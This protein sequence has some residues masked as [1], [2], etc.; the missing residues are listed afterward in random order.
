M[1]EARGDIASATR[2]DTNAGGAVARERGF[3]LWLTVAPYA[4]AFF[5]IA[6]LRQV[7][8]GGDLWVRLAS[9]R[10]VLESHAVPR[11]DPFSFSAVGATWIDHEW[12]LGTA[13][14]LMYRVHYELIVVVF[15][16]LA[17]AP[18]IVMHRHVLVNRPAAWL[19][20]LGIVAVA[21]AAAWRNYPPR[22]A[23][24]NPLCFAILLTLIDTHRFD[25][26]KRRRLSPVFLAIPLMFVW[27]N[28]QAGFMVGF[29][30]LAI[31]TVVCFIERR[32]R[33]LA[34]GITLVALCAGLANAYGWRL[35]TYTLWASIGGSAD[36]NIVQEWLSPDFHTPLN[37]PHALAIVV[38]LRFTGRPM[39]P[40]RQTML[41]GTLMASLLSAR[42]QPFFAVALIFAVVPA[43][44]SVARPSRLR[45]RML[46]YAAAP[47]VVLPVA[48]FIAALPNGS[49]SAHQPHAALAFVRQTYPGEHV[50]ATI[51]I[52]SWLTYEREPV[53]IDGRTSQ[54]YSN[55]LVK[56]YFDLVGAHGNWEATLDQHEINVVMVE[57][58]S[59]LERALLSRGWR[60]VF[61]EE[62]GT[63]FT[64]PGWGASRAAPAATPGSRR[65]G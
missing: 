40:F 1:S 33:Q 65:G 59:V 47:V 13:M 50:L 9:G 22:P 41:V 26:A 28:L 49:P 24:V 52:S 23:L 62:F 8:L 35:Y 20:T 19:P 4:S 18:F 34:L 5:G 21:I 51:D 27:A 32:D 15:A 45:L 7:L 30:V 55:D 46:S 56:E 6:F 61:S 16:L 60:E 39:D 38:A 14:Y 48:F 43:L 3:H 54:I 29:A 17:L 53:F 25:D 12:I 36:R 2:A 57:P 44:G 37:W 31:W 42:F 63:V 58:D 10:L 64:R 11:H